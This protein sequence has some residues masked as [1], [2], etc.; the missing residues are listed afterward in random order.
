MAHEPPPIACTL[1]DA[2]LKTRLAELRALGEDGLVSNV[3]NG[4]SAVLRFRPAPD[5][6]RRVDAAVAAESECCPFLDFELEHGE[7][8]TVLTI[9]APDGAAEALAG[10]LS[11]R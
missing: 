5:I 3:V 4:R 11:G 2:D 9:T 7:D 6:R 1:G 10:V 8:A